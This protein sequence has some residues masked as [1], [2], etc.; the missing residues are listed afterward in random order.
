MCCCCV[1]PTRSRGRGSWMPAASCC[2]CG[3]CHRK[4]GVSAVCSAPAARCRLLR[5]VWDS[6]LRR[7]AYI[8]TPQHA[9]LFFEPQRERRE[10]RNRPN[11]S[12]G[13]VDFRNAI[14][15][16]HRQPTQARESLETYLPLSKPI[17][18][19]LRPVLSTSSASTNSSVPPDGPTRTRPTQS[20]AKV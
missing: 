17:D 10:R 12:K 20:L 19:Q 8:E 6:C 13:S 2:C 7:I 15:P 11:R 3:C 1:A 16:S 4:V 14:S 9:P 5:S 18:L